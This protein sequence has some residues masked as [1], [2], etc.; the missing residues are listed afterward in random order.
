M[1]LRML[2]H[3]SPELQ[4]KIR[5]TDPL[6]VN[7]CMNTARG[8]GGGGGRCV[9]GYSTFFKFIIPNHIY[10]K[11]FERL[12]EPLSVRLQGWGQQQGKA[13]KKKKP[14][15]GKVTSL[16]PAHSAAS[17]P[18]LRESALPVGVVLNPSVCVVMWE[19]RRR[20]RPVQ[21][22]QRHKRKDRA[23]E[24]NQER[25]INPS[26]HAHMHIN[27]QESRVERQREA[28]MCGAGKPSVNK[29]P[30]CILNSPLGIHLPRL[31][32]RLR[33]S[34]LS[35]LVFWGKRSVFWHH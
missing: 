32:T 5:A 6:R 29:L 19:L 3:S 12:E 26:T 15:M 2:T 28:Q 9:L 24:C 4:R 10:Q 21:E 31:K 8:W 13:K 14:S 20:S 27:A 22:R 7:S 30:A 33:I 25:L 17:V 35:Q 16:R 11:C 34:D 23:R 1:I 18:F